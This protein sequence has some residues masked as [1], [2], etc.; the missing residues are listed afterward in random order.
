MNTCYRLTTYILYIYLYHDK[1]SIM[2]HSYDINYCN[3]RL[4]NITHIDILHAAVAI[5]NVILYRSIFAKRSCENMG[6]RDY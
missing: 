3:V 1:V 4:S 6:A 5:Y 2:S